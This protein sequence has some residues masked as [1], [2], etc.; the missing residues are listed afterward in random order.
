MNMHKLTKLMILSISLTILSV[1]ISFSA[2]GW[3]VQLSTPM[4]AV[5]WILSVLVFFMR[6]FRW[7]KKDLKKR[8]IKEAEEEKSENKKEKKSEIEYLFE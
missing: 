7:Y 3:L 6:G 2:T 5:F 4:I 8:A 1:I